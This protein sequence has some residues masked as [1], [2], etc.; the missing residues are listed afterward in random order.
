MEKAQQTISAAK[1]KLTDYKEYLLDDNEKKEII[2]E[3]KDG[4][5]A[6]VKEM[7]TTLN[8]FTGLFKDA[9]YEIKGIDASISVPPGMSITF[10][11]LEVIPV[12]EREQIYI[13]AENNRIASIILK[14]LFKASD[15]SDL[16]KIGDF[17]LRSVTLKLGVIPAI[18]IS[19]L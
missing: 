1:E 3:F 5:Q 18:N 10:K 16:V 11:C 19:F 6:K 12:S 7:L 17:R 13:K 8:D 15:F 14:S 2:E 4:G 9:G